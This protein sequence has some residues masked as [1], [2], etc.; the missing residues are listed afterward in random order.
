MLQPA[1]SPPLMETYL[2]DRGTF[3]TMASMFW[4][5]GSESSHPTASA[6]MLMDSLNPTCPARVPSC[7]PV[8]N[9]SGERPTP[10]SSITAGPKGERLFTLSALIESISAQAPVSITTSRSMIRPGFIPVPRSVTPSLFAAACIFSVSS[11]SPAL[12]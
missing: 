5:T 8:S 1:T 3:E 12:G 4:L 7:I 11:G 9:C 2:V 6:I 10:C